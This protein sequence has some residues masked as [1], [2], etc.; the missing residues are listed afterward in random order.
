MTTLVLASTRVDVR[1]SGYDLRVAKLCA[2]I[3]DELHLI[4]VPVHPLPVR[5]PSIDTSTVFASVSE[6]PPLLAGP[7]SPRRHLRLEVE[8]LPSVQ[9]GEHLVIAEDGAEFAGAVL[10]LLDEA[11][12]LRLRANANALLHE[13]YRWSVVG[14]PWRA[15]FG[16]DGL[17]VRPRQSD[18]DFLGA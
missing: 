4:V 11:L 1:E 9:D 17:G 14:R 16:A 6:C 3:P 5:T 2:L 13:R 12:R 8:A 10:K 7:R 15:L 18:A